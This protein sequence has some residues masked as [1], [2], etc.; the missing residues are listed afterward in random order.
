MRKINIE[1]HKHRLSLTL[2]YSVVTLLLLVA[3]AAIVGVVIAILVH[4]GILKFMAVDLKM[5]SF[6]LSL[7]L[8]SFLIG[9]VLVFITSRFSLR[10]VNKIINA[11]NRL[12]SGDYSTRLTFKKATGKLPSAKEFAESFNTMAEELEH[13]EMLRSD[14]VNNFSHEFKT[15][16]VSIAGFVKVLRR[17]N[18]TEEKTQEYLAVIEEESLRL[19]EMATNVLNLTNVENQNILT[20]VKT[21]NLSEQIRTCILMLE[22]K[23]TK[24]NIELSLPGEEY[25]INANEELMKQVWINLIDN[26]IKFSQDYGLLEVQIRPVGQELHV[27]VSNFGEPIPEESMDKIWNKFYQ[28]DKS[29][30]TKGNGVGLA[31]VKK[32]VD[33]HR[34]SAEGNCTG[35]KT[36]FTVILPK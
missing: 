17:G 36:T 34:G 18:L 23:W 15:P 24:K 2:M 3:T 1:E 27:S 31:V 25:Y 7:I 21:Y 26:A 35:G 12:A 19:S 32:I 16:I 8:F 20:D 6:I 30:T 4:N 33:M 28:A 5:G 13:T 29:H 9:L 10:P 11:M 22:R 14:F